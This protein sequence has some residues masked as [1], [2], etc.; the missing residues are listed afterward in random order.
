MASNIRIG[1]NFESKSGGHPV[2]VMCNEHNWGLLAIKHTTK[3]GMGGGAKAD[4]MRCSVPAIVKRTEF[5]LFGQK[6]AVGCPR[7]F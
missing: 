6:K 7:A 4:V 1:S 5:F 2:R 3:V